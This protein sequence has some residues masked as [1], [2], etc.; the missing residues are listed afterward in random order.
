MEGIKLEPE[1]TFRHETPGLF[2]AGAVQPAYQYTPTGIQPCTFATNIQTRP[3]HLLSCGHVVAIDID[4]D[5]SRCGVNCLHTIDWLKQMNADRLDNKIEIGEF[6]GKDSHFSYT[7]LANEGAHLVNRHG[8]SG[9]RHHLLRNLSRHPRLQ[10][11]HL[12]T[13]GRATDQRCGLSYPP[14]H[15]AL[16]RL[17]A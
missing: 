15:S 2:D 17:R 6:L 12:E 11:V 8:I 5:D 10:L 3:Y 7:A 9:A 1:F 4:A 14:C 13:G 16:H